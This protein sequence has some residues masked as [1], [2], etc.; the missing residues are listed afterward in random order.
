MLCIV[1]VKLAMNV[2]ITAFAGYIFWTV[3]KRTSETMN[4][5]KQKAKEVRDKEMK[6]KEETRMLD[7]AVTTLFYPSTDAEIVA[8]NEFLT[9][10][11]ANAARTVE[12]IANNCII[13]LRNNP[14]EL[15]YENVKNYNAKLDSAKADSELAAKLANIYSLNSSLDRTDYEEADRLAI[16]VY[17]I[18][19]AAEEAFTKADAY[20]TCKAFGF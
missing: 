17:N 8:A 7:I 4:A 13:E 11:A 5:D 16:L 18:A 9:A 12:D 6:R 15:E 20:T 14:T 19:D 10:N 3:L 2:I 1:I